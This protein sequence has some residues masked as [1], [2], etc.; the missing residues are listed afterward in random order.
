MYGGNPDEYSKLGRLIGFII[1]SV[2]GWSIYSS[3]KVL[4]NKEIISDSLII[5]ELKLTI[6][7]NVVDTTY[8]YKEK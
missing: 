1:L 7:N 6:K 2:I 5:P 3:Y 8:I 4:S